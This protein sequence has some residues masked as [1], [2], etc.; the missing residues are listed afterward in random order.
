MGSTLGVKCDLILTLRSQI[1]GYLRDFFLQTCLG[2]PAIGLFR[3]KI[4]GKKKIVFFLRK[5]LSI[6]EPFEGR[7]SVGTRFRRWRQ[8]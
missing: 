8:S 4:R 7:W 3:Q 6:I 5:R 1:F 2:V